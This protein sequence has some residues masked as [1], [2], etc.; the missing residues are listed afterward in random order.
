MRSQ[1]PVFM[2]AYRSYRK[3]I[4]H[5][6]IIKLNA[7]ANLYILYTLNTGTELKQ[8]KF[9]TFGKKQTK[10]EIAYENRNRNRFKNRSGNITDSSLWQRRPRQWIRCHSTPSSCR[11]V[12]GDA[13]DC[14]R[15]MAPIYNVTATLFVT[16]ITLTPVQCAEHTAD[17]R[18]DN[19][20]CLSR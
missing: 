18:D 17:V 8:T 15:F 13:P 1:T 14:R 20:M 11:S 9:K 3:K 7:L 4:F 16:W 2:Y 6:S 12:I 10:T 19:I 5:V